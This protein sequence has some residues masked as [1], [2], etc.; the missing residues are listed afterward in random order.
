MTF[1]D[2]V[3]FEEDKVLLSESTPKEVAILFYLIEPEDVRIVYHMS[4]PV[5]E[6]GGKLHKNRI[7]DWNMDMKYPI[8]K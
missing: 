5:C 6:C 3:T 2:F 4:N 8:Y 1:N 7:N